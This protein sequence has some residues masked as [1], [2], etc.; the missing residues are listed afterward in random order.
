MRKSLS[1][2]VLLG[3]SALII[4]FILSSFY[5]VLN[6][7][8]KHNQSPAIETDTTQADTGATISGEIGTANSGTTDETE[9]KDIIDTLVNAPETTEDSEAE[10]AEEESEEIDVI[11]TPGQLIQERPH[12]QNAVP[13]VPQAP[14]S[15]QGSPV[16]T[17]P[18]E[19]SYSETGDSGNQGSFPQPIIVEPPAYNNR[20]GS[21]ST[22]APSNNSG[23]SSNFPAPIISG[24]GS[25]AMS[26]LSRPAPA[27]SASTSNNSAFPA[28]II[29]SNSAN[30]NRRSSSDFPA[31]Q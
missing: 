4:I 2:L 28:P 30:S 25:S 13:P 1:T 6:R 3:I 12:L 5:K 22:P 23:A 14:P 21:S 11:G 9:A 31:P 19:Q 15:P 20:N 16:I 8:P 10:L 18:D 29:N 26:D 7:A 27:P 17:A 24:S